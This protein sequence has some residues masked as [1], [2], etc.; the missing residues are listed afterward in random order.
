MN[1]MDI[2][3]TAQLAWRR[4]NVHDLSSSF[5]ER[6]SS[7]QMGS[8][9]NERSHD[10]KKMPEWSPLDRSDPRNPCGYPPAR[11]NQELGS[12]VRKFVSDVCNLL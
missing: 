10:Q 8:L 3:E 6:A 5:T 12:Q 11:K 9:L 4:L 2:S 7:S 1:E